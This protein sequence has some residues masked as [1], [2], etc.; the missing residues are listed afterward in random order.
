MSSYG[1]T[2][3][4]L[5][6][7][8]SWFF[9]QFYI[10]HCME[11]SVAPFLQHFSNTEHLSASN[12]LEKLSFKKRSSNGVSK[13]DRLIPVFW[14]YM[15]LCRMRISRPEIT[16]TGKSWVLLLDTIKARNPIDISELRRYYQ[17]SSFNLGIS[18]ELVHLGSSPIGKWS[19]GRS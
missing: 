15:L 14:I 10:F 9:A 13:G 3:L 19:G 5:S 16:L 12:V 6:W 2:M 7:G 18:Y 1:V 8:E 17:I 11:F 4:E